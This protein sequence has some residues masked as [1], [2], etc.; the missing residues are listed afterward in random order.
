MFA[1][2]DTAQLAVI[3]AYNGPESNMSHGAAK[4]HEGYLFEGVRVIG[5]GFRVI[6]FRVLGCRVLGLGVLGCRA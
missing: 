4:R 1:P 2:A 5:I 3:D 6:G